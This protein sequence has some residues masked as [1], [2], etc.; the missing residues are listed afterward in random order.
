[1][2]KHNFTIA[3]DSLACFFMRGTVGA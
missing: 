2:Y 3:I 1:L